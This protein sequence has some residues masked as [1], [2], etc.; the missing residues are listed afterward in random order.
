MKLSPSEGDD[1]I[2]YLFA[3]NHETIV[4][5]CTVRLTSLN[6]L[7]HNKKR[8]DQRFHRPLLAC[9]FITVS[10]FSLLDTMPLRFGYTFY[11]SACAAHIIV[12]SLPTYSA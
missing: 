7:S 10:L 9:V 8:H 4:C 3:F 11:L 5:L 1:P 6:L 12:I 2:L